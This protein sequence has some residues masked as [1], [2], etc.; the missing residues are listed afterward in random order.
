MSRATKTCTNDLLV[1]VSQTCS[2][3]HYC[4]DAQSALIE[5]RVL[6]RQSVSVLQSALCYSSLGFA[7]N[8][9]QNNN[10]NCVFLLILVRKGI[11]TNGAPGLTSNKNAT[12]VTKDS[13]AIY[14]ESRESLPQR[15]AQTP[16]ALTPDSSAVT[17]IVQAVTV[18]KCPSKP[19]E[20]LY[21]CWALQTQ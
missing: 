17:V 16:K 3:Q 4:P 19:L 13:L 12:N 15:P 6:G 1:I 14:S 8:L 20:V 7:E 11:A 21:T 2:Y 10:F 5:S 9:L 18:Y